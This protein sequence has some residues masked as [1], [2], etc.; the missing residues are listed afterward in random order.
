MIVSPEP[1]EGTMRAARAT[2]KPPAGVM[3]AAVE[4]YGRFWTGLR[5]DGTGALRALAR[6]DFCFSDPFN[7]LRGAD[8]VVA[9]LDHLFARASD[10]RFEIRRQAWSDDT[11]FYRW[12][13]GCRLRRPAVAASIVG[14]SEVR[15]D[16]TGLVA[17]HVDHW[18]AAS[19][20]YERI[21]ALGAVLRLL[22]RRLAVP[23]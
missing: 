22:R 14:V 2:G 20:V 7:E 21:P 13:F 18:D 16:E 1:N 5:P 8:R 9:L 11:A 3:P 6:P 10:V 17:T 12:D 23:G 15:F 19:Q 4:R